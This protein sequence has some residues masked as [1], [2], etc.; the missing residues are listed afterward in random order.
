MAR[1]ERGPSFR[2][3]SVGNSCCG[4]DFFQTESSRYDI[5]RLGMV[6]ADRV[7]SAN[8]LLIQGTVNEKLAEAVQD[9]FS[10]M[11]KP[12]FVMAIGTCACGG[13]FFPVPMEV[14]PKIDILVTGCPPRPEAIMNGVIALHEKVRR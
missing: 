14:V 11:E 7:E 5:E 1:I 2:Y 6:A 8:L 9:C 10:R 13:G 3:F 12:S 4:D